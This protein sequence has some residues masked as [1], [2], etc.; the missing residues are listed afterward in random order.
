MGVGVHLAMHLLHAVFGLV[1]GLFGTLLDAVTYVFG[2]VFGFVA[3]GLHVLFG[4]GV[5]LGLCEGWKAESE[6]G[7]QGKA[8]YVLDWHYVLHGAAESALG[9]D[10]QFDRRVA[11]K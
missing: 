9:I 1:V 8:S 6:C 10:S 3:R 5:S 7:R 2:G 11:R 4:S